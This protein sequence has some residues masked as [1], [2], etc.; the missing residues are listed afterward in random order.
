MFTQ[1]DLNMQQQRWLELI[2]DYDLEVHYHPGKANVVADSFNRK[3]HCNYLI[4]ESYNGTLCEELR[5]LALEIIRQGE[6]N[7]ISIKA[8]LYDKI[9]V[10]QPSDEGVK[11]IKQKL[12]ENDPN[13]VCFRQDEKGTI[14]FGQRLVVPEEATIRKEIFDQAHLS[15]FSI[16]PRSSKMYQDF[17]E[18]FWWSNMKV[19]IAIYD[20]KCDTCLRVKASHLKTAGKLQPL[21]IPSWKWDDTSMDFVVGL[22][23][24]PRNHDSIWVIV[25]RLTKTVHFIAIHTT[26][27]TKKYAYLYL[28]R[29]HLHRIP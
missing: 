5:K 19:E 4:V 21:P 17:K 24:T 6:L 7:S 20:S 1:A 15:K 28:D 3:A 25:D 8:T 14:W 2:K 22:P 29:I 23:L 12:S 9:I 27:S 11:A 10:A 13:Y 16:H 26:Y 18:I